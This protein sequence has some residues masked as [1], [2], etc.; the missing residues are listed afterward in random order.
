MGAYWGSC[1]VAVTTDLETSRVEQMDLKPDGVDGTSDKVSC[2]IPDHLEKYEV[3]DDSAL[4]KQVVRR[5]IWLIANEQILE[6]VAGIEH[7]KLQREFIRDIEPASDDNQRRVDALTDS[8]AQ[9]TA[10]LKRVRGIKRAP[11]RVV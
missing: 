6:L 9:M 10:E 2:S 1:Y 3:F 5:H 11:I 8:L 4:A 7:A